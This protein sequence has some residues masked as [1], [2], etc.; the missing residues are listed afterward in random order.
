MEINIIFMLA[1][2]V[3]AVFAILI[4]GKKLDA[5]ENCISRISAE[6]A[7]VMHYIEEMEDAI[8][9]GR[10]DVCARLSIVTALLNDIRRGRNGQE[11]QAE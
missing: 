7:D 6:Y 5:M 8:R 3:I 1:A 2:V 10:S 9:D 11:D 4:I